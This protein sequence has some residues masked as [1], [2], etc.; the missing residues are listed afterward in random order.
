MKKLFKNE[1]LRKLDEKWTQFGV[2]EK[3]LKKAYQSLMV[4][5]WPLLYKA[6]KENPDVVDKDVTKLL[7]TLENLSGSCFDKDEVLSCFHDC[8]LDALIYHDTLSID[9]K[10][11]LVFPGWADDWV[12]NPSTFEFQDE[13]PGYDED[14]DIDWREV[15]CENESLKEE[16]EKTLNDFKISIEVLVEPDLD[17]DIVSGNAK[18]IYD[19]QTLEDWYDF[20]SNVEGL[21][22]KIGT[23]MNVSE[24]KQSLSQYID[25]YVNNKNGDKLEGLIGLRLSDYKSTS[26]ARKLRKKKAQKIDQNYRLVSINVNKKQFDSYEDALSHIEEL[27]K[28]L[29]KIN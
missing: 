13:I 18:E 17:E 15:D 11:N 8:L 26:N 4:K 28:I 3:N 24:S 29:L 27:F 19:D 2:D 12:I 10:G 14:V 25:F 6:W 20:A 1:Q 9:E 7:C 21:I 23:V 5:T 22:D 16:K